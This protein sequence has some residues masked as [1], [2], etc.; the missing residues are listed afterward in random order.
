MAELDTEEKFKVDFSEQRLTLIAT[1]A[2]DREEIQHLLCSFLDNIYLEQLTFQFEG[3]SQSEPFLL[4][5]KELKDG[6]KLFYTHGDDHC[7]VNLKYI[8]N[9]G[10][11][12]K[13]LLMFGE[14][15]QVFCTMY[16]ANDLKI[17]Y[18]TFIKGTKF[19]KELIV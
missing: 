1:N 12:L 17:G 4:F 2:I 5:A 3:K 8:P 14:S 13:N 10:F 6:E 16:R 7:S 19:Q 11:L 9:S 15:N 18:L